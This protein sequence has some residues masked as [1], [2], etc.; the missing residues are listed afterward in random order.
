MPPK[1]LATMVTTT[2]YGT[3]LPGDARGYV[4]NGRILPGDPKLLQHAR[5]LLSKS[6]VYFNRSQQDSLFEA[7]WR[8]TEEFLT[9]TDFGGRNFGIRRG[10]RRPEGCGAS[11][12]GSD[13]G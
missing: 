3:W 5:S 10:R 2:S 8:A 9:V 1:I 4:D 11:S 7:L 12:H 13:V 6:P